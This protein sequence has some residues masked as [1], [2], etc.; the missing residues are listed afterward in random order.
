MRLENID[1]A[2]HIDLAVDS[3]VGAQNGDGSW[4]DFWLPGGAS[5]EW[6][7]AYTGAALALVPGERAQRSAMRGWEFLA[8]QPPE[9]GGWGYS[10]AT[11]P[12]TDSTAWACI[13]AERTSQRETAAAKRG[14][15]FLAATPGA[16]AATYTHDEAIR[17]FTTADANLS[18]AGW[19]QPHWCVSGAVALAPEPTDALLDAIARAQRPDGSWQSYW[20][21]VDLYATALCS[22]ALAR[23]GYGAAA[24]D[25]AARY[26]Q[27]AAA[28]ADDAFALALAT[29]ACASAG[30]DSAAAAFA[31]RLA[32][33]QRSDGSWQRAAWLRVPAP[34]VIDPENVTFEPWT[35]VLAPG[36]TAAMCNFSSLDFMRTFTAATAVFA[37]AL[38]AGSQP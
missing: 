26:A 22:A 38:V 3:L 11:P 34:D 13:L 2:G 16:G 28:G 31:Q 7:T 6:V 21:C 32:G 23:H 30:E 4:H 17:T 5:D 8:A 27:M 10:R 33:V 20:W 15:E 29:I 35:G 37:L 36:R 18:F 1:I 19:T 12:D 9:R 24:C 14:A 25:R